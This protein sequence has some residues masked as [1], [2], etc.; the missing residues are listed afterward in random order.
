[1]ATRRADE[2]RVCDQCHGR[3][4]GLA[5]CVHA[6][7]WRLAILAGGLGCVV[8]CCGLVALFC[9]SR[10]GLGGL[11]SAGYFVG[12]HDRG[13][14][15]HADGR[16]DPGG[17]QARLDGHCVVCCFMDFGRVVSRPT[18]NGFSLGCRRLRAPSKHFGRLCA[19]ARCLWHGGDCRMGGHGRA[20]ACF[21]AH[22]RKNQSLACAG[23]DLA[24]GVGGHS[25]GPAKLRR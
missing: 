21:S 18:F 13:A 6:H 4:L 20:S 10:W 2:R 23:S 7:I 25:H 14:V 16:H 3:H 17:V 22:G 11:V 9:G 12:P 5:V 19:L 15:C 8:A 24:H 1:M